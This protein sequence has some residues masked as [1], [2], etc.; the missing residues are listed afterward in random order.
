MRALERTY[1]LVI[2]RPVQI[3]EKPVNIETYANT[4]KG[5]AYEIKELHID[6]SIKKDNSKDPNKGYVTVYN[7][8]DEIVNYLGTHQRDSLAVLLKAGY[9]GD[10]KLIF[11][12][13][14]EY[15]EDNFPNETRET[16]FILG[17]GTLNLTTATTARSYKKGTPMNS[18]LNDLISDLKL[19]KGRVVD[20][21]GDTLEHSMAFTG[22]ASQNLANLA[23]NTGAS[24]SVQDGAVYWTR[25]GS[26]FNNVMFEISEEGG[27]VGVPSVKQPS[28]SKKLVSA[29]AK[30]KK[31]ADAGEKPKSPS[32]KKKKKK[33]HDIREDVGIS[34]STLLNGAILPESTV[35]LN[36]RYHK[37]FYKVAELTHRGG[38][39]SGEW[40]TELGLVE[41]RGELIK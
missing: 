32:K 11:S 21:G 29:K 12:G 33:E 39:E 6:F 38:Y 31:K 30:A 23:K 2:G 13:T 19:P 28:S 16:K 34:V 40:V 15:V 9:N 3:G 22:N 1:T 7:L 36:T 20:F 4:N 18:V 24:F 5:D 41:T 25:Q 14:V 37:G 26:R 27:M 8:S 35:Y 10:E 17:D